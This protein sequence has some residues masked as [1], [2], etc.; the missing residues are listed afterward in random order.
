M[1]KGFVKM[2]IKSR[3]PYEVTY[4]FRNGVM[5]AEGLFAEYKNFTINRWLDGYFPLD[6]GKET[7]VV[8]EIRFVLD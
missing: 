3:N 1:L 7:W 4:E 2:A 5:S 6:D 8:S